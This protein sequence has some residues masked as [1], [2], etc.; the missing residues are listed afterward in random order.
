MSYTFLQEQGEES[1]V[2]CFSDIEQFV[3][4]KLSLTAGK[5]SCNDNETESC[6]GSQFGT[7]CEPLMGN[8]GGELQTLCVE[9]SPAK[10]LVAPGK[11]VDLKEN[12]LDYGKKWQEW[13]VKLDPDTFL[14]KTR[15]CSL[16]EDL[17]QSLKIWPRWGIMRN[18]ECYEVTMPEYL[19]AVRVC[20]LSPV[21]HNKVPKA[22]RIKTPSML[23]AIER[24]WMQEVATMPT[25]TT[26]IRERAPCPYWRTPIGVR[27]LTEGEAEAL[28]DWPIGWGGKKPL[29]MDKYQVWRLAHGLR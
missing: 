15:Q 26:K 14:W 21:P 24:G 20:G 2:E 7:M 25:L 29:E 3:R 16:F 10:T 28:M 13:F 19:N 12:D 9:G 1:S 6:R 8:R 5:S 18:G 4:L 27:Y 23:R 11:V 22:Y 17:E